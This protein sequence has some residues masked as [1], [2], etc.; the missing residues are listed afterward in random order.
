MSIS[1][2]GTVVINEQ[3]FSISKMT[4]WDGAIRFH[5]VLSGP[6]RFPLK[7]EVRVHGPDG[8]LILTAPW[9]ITEADVR[10]MSM[11][12]RD[13]FTYIDLPVKVESVVGWPEE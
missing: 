5:I 2:Y 7:S 9:V 4:L 13:G 12:T 1:Y 8:S 10:N 11:V 3:V 6:Q